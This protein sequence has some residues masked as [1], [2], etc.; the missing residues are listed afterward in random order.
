AEVAKRAVE[1]DERDLLAV[2]RAERGGGFAEMRARR[3][4]QCV[5]PSVR[6]EYT[7]RLETG[8][9]GDEGDRG[10]AHVADVLAREGGCRDGRDR[11]RESQRHHVFVRGAEIGLV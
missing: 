9:T 10:V 3:G 11:L 5:M 2:A 8:R 4:E 1:A 7:I 6:D